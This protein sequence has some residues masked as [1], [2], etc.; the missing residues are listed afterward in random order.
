MALTQKGFLI[1]LCNETA[2]G[3]SAQADKQVGE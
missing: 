1:F 2:N 3:L